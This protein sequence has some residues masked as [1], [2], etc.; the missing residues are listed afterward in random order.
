MEQQSERFIKQQRMMVLMAIICFVML[1]FVIAFG[2]YVFDYSSNKIQK[3]N[4]A[5]AALI[6][7]INLENNNKTSDVVSEEVPISDVDFSQK[8]PIDYSKLTAEEV[9]KLVSNHILLTEGEVT[10]ASITNIEGLRADYPE[11]F[12][13]A[14]NNDKLIFYSLGIIIYDPV[15]DKVVDVVRR[16]PAG[17]VIPQSVNDET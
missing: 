11:L 16:L 6:K 3:N 5:V 14:K 10:V 8:T 9:I 12:A 2:W 4:E 15:L 1:I 13:Y 17:T 7:N